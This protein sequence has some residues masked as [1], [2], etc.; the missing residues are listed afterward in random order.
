MSVRYVMQRDTRG[1]RTQVRVS[2]GLSL[3][4]TAFG[5]LN[6]PG[7]ELDRAFLA[8]GMFFCLFAT[9]AVSK[10]VRDNRDGQVD[11]GGWMATVWAGFAAAMLL[12]AWGLFR[13]EVPDW[14]KYYV[15]VCWLYLVSSAFVLA[16]TLR[17]DQ[18]ANLLERRMAAQ[19]RGGEGAA[20]AAAPA[21]ASEAAA[22]AQPPRSRS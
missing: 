2:F 7:A 4:C 22:P 14:Q 17:D 21:S 18:E 11:T 3:L 6:L 20:P 13:M 12:T 5:V 16:K 15:V 8:M 9:L 19:A 10:L 1:W